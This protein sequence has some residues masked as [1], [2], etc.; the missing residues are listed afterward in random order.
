MNLLQNMLE[1]QADT[2]AP[3]IMHTDAFIDYA[4]QSLEEILNNDQAKPLSYTQSLWTEL[5]TQIV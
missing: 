2:L 5:L 1:I 3:K 4:L